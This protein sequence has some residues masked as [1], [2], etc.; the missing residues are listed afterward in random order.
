[1]LAYFFSRPQLIIYCDRPLSEV[2]KGF[3][4]REQLSGVY[5]NLTRLAGAYDCFM[6]FV[7]FMA[8]INPNIFYTEYDFADEGANRGVDF[9]VEKYLDLVKEV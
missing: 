5:E 8:S 3:E 4:G 6:K 1:M 9:W 7:L 2:R